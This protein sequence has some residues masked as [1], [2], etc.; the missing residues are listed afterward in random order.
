MKP[1]RS[2][3]PNPTASERDDRDGNRN[4]RKQVRE[5]H[6]D[7]SAIFADSVYVESLAP[8]RYRRDRNRAGVAPAITNAIYHATGVRMPTL[9]AKIEDLLAAACQVALALV[10]VVD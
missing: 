7:C 6:D 2:P 5:R 3:S 4:D 8:A 10:G 9:S 1:L